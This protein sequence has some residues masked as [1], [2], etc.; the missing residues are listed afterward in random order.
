[1]TKS[2]DDMPLS[3]DQLRALAKMTAVAAEGQCLEQLARAGI[4]VVNCIAM[5]LL[6]QAEAMNIK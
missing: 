4:F 6:K 3:V 2:D 1:M 5:T